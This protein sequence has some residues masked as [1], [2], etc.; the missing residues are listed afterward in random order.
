[1]SEGSATAKTD[2]SLN[3][4]A[5][6]STADTPSTSEFA[7]GMELGLL[8]R[9]AD[10]WSTLQEYATPE[11][12]DGYRAPALSSPRDQDTKIAGLAVPTTTPRPFVVSFVSL[13][14]WEG[15]VEEVA[16]ETFSA[17]LVDVRGGG[18]T[19][20]RADEI[21]LSDLTAAERQRLKPGAVFRWAI[22]HEL[23]RA[24]E[25]KRVSSIVFR[26]LPMWTKKEIDEARQTGER[27]AAAIRWD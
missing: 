21:P 24:G 16:D 14:E 11:P 18:E 17:T 6:G 22:G 1:M 4:E 2:T 20:F 27:R 15:V 10:V 5:L 9:Q 19:T 7:H 8:R 13:S 3:Q 25:K 26:D 23:T 12:S